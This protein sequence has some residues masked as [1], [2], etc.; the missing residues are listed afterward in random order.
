LGATT[1]LTGAAQESVSVSDDACEC[2][3]TTGVAPAPGVARCAGVENVPPPEAKEG[4]DGDGDGDG[5]APAAAPAPASPAPEARRI[6]PDEKS[7]IM[8]NAEPCGL[9]AIYNATRLCRSGGKPILTINF[10][11]A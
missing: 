10:L 4:V 7:P 3:A 5:E 2:D 9:C 11:D 6:L 8:P 1:G